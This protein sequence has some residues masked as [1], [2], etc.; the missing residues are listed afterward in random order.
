MLQQR[1]QFGILVTG[2]SSLSIGLWMVYPPAMFIC[3]GVLLLSGVV[4]TRLIKG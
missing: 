1:I 2:L 4:A 3:D